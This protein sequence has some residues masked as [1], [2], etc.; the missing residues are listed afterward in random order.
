MFN[1]GSSGTSLRAGTWGGICYVLQSQPLPH[2]FLPT[3]HASEVG[4]LP[5]LN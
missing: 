1:I 5:T 2:V 3:V 4:F